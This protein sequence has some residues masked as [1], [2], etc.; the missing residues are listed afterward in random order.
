MMSAR[1]TVKRAVEFRGPEWTPYS[2]GITPQQLEGH[3]S[4]AQIEAL[5]VALRENGACEADGHF[6]AQPLFAN[7]APNPTSLP[8]PYRPL[9]ADEWVDE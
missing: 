5:K 2:V 6:Y 7:V 4:P 9:A 3:C 8:E 1:E